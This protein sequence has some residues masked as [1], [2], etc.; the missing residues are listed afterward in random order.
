[1]LP[2]TM[3]AR[4]LMK[5][6][7]L[8]LDNHSE[9]TEFLESIR[10]MNKTFER[11]VND[12]PEDQGKERLLQYV[13]MLQKEMD[14][15][16]DILKTYEEGYVTTDVSKRRD[17]MLADWFADKIVYITSEALIW[18]IPIGLVLRAVMKSQNSKLV[19]GKPIPGDAPGKF[20]KGPNYRPPEE[21]IAAILDRSYDIKE[22][23]QEH[24]DKPEEQQ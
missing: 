23:L 20:G 17:V 16:K 10:N 9:W 6:L 15:V 19:D 1:M 22:A 12:L 5:R 7:Q 2:T 13:G 3:K 11:P 8:R 14:E 24:G 18:G 4:W 21:E